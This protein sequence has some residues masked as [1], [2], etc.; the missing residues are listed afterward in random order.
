MSRQSAWSPRRLRPRLKRLYVAPEF[1]GRGCG[2]AALEAVERAA[3]QL[4]YEAVR[5]DCQRAN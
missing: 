1:R 2:A 3:E 5:I 4:G